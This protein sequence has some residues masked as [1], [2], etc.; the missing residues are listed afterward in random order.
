[1]V[2]AG[3]RHHMMIEK[4]TSL[5]II[6]TR[7]LLF[8]AIVAIIIIVCI[9]VVIVIDEII[10]L[11]LLLKLLKEIVLDEF[12]EKKPDALLTQKVVAALVG[13]SWRRWSFTV[14]IVLLLIV[15]VITGE[16]ECCCRG[17]RCLHTC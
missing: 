10:N 2:V 9:L 3:R 4:F 1:M 6:A 12:V 5:P 8:V 14:L 16:K 7:A 13:F 15:C 17:R 11:L